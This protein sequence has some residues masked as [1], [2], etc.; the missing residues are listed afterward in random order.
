MTRLIDTCDALD[1]QLA[2]YL[3]TEL[4]VSTRQ[5][6]DA[7]VASCLRCSALLRDL[8]ALSHE[9][10]A[11]PALTPSRDLWEG[12]A[13]R[14]ETGVIPLPARAGSHRPTSVQ[15]TTVRQP[16]RY[17]SAAVAA[18]LMAVTAGVTYALTMAFGVSSTSTVATAPR[19][20]PPDT[21]NAASP[22]IPSPLAPA[23]VASA[24]DTVQTPARTLPE[25]EPSPVRLV[26]RPRPSLEQTYDREI[27]ALRV[28]LTQRGS[29]LDPKT[30]AIV[31]NS[32]STIDRAIA[33]ARGALQ[34][35]PASRFLNEQL[36][37]ALEKK[38]ELLRTAALLPSRT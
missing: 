22:V 32:L 20:L 10:R 19:D 12:I 38:L 25:T 29:D 26:R 36:T 34:R 21:A 33:E 28:I 8:R 27:A 1:E 30:A 31:E 7:H 6:V 3:E 23:I 2:A 35:D 18:G 24:P 37:K 13:T 14:I 11:L 17:S 9:A 5:A 15:A 16:R 4:D